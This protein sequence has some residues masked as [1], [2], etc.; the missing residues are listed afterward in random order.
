MHPIR[1]H[2]HEHP[3][4]WCGPRLRFIV[5]RRTISW[6]LPL[7]M[8]KLAIIGR[9]PTMPQWHDWRFDGD[10][11]GYDTVGKAVHACREYQEFHPE[12]WQW[13]IIVVEFDCRVREKDFHPER[14]WLSELTSDKPKMPGQIWGDVNAAQFFFLGG[15][16]I[17]G[18]H[19][20]RYEF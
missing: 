4:A 9:N 5:T 11:D 13:S 18:P 20:P 19:G 6:L 15:C 16:D 8:V 2:M 14:L 10:Y 17:A 12:P 7:Y 1:L 3:L